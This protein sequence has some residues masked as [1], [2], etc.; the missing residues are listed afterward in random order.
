M[1]NPIPPTIHR[2]QELTYDEL[3]ERQADIYDAIA[4]GPRG[5]VRGPLAVWLHHPGLAT[6]AQKLGHYCR[7]NSFLPERLSELAIL[8]M[9]AEWDATYEWIAHE[10]HALKAGINQAVLEELK[11]GN[12]PDFANPDEYLV[13]A[14]VL[15]L[16]RDK[17]VDNDLYQ[18]IVDELGQ[19]A[20]IDLVGI[21]G[22]Y[23]LVSMT[24]KA[25]DIRP[26]E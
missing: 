20:V 24:I 7:Y 13:Y 6:P 16:L 26:D 11:Y 22:Y 5:G 3:D 19:D 18:N 4:S 9:A 12:V 25:F 21:A 2:I 10:K 17:Q 15:S 8:I 1:S 14:F 23:T